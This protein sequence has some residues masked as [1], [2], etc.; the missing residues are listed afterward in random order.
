MLQWV[1]LINGKKR[2]IIEQESVSEDVY[3]F[4]TV[5]VEKP[6]KKNGVVNSENYSVSI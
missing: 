4:E 5:Q 6:K 2:K 1:L 3:G